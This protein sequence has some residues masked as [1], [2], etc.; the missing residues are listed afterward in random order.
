M[1][2]AVDWDHPG[3][4]VGGVA[5]L[6]LGLAEGGGD[7]VA[8]D[9]AGQPLRL[10][11]RAAPY[12][13][14]VAATAGHGDHVVRAAGG[15]DRVVD[16]GQGG[17]PL[18]ARFLPRGQPG[19]EDAPALVLARGGLAGGRPQSLGRITTPLPS[20]LRTSS[21]SLVHG[22]GTRRA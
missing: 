9:R 20:A 7:D 19:A 8:G 12:L 5:G 13:A 2:G 10:G 22:T 4:R 14:L 6:G 15:R 16:A 1:P 21:T 18:A 11:V 3:A 17:H